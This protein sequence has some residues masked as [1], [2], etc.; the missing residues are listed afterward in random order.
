[1][2]MSYYKAAQQKIAVARIK[3]LFNEAKNVFNKDCKL[4]D[5][6]VKLARCIAMK[7]KIRLSSQLKKSI[8]KHCHKYLVPSNNCRVR[9]HKHK[10]IYYCLNCKHYM[11][12]LIK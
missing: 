6:Y 11:R 10:L 2:M 8:C 3:L 5:K 4:A 12:Y 9:I 7:Y 1:M